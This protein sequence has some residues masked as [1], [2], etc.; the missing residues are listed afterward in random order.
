MRIQKFNDMN[1]RDQAFYII[2]HELGKEYKENGIVRAFIELA[3]LD[4][5]TINKALVSCV[6]VLC[7]TNANPSNLQMVSDVERMKIQ[8]MLEKPGHVE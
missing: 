1:N 6:K 3:I 5:I 7:A 8:E 4:K 2:S